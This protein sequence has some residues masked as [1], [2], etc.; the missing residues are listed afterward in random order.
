VKQNNQR[1]ELNKEFP[2]MPLKQKNC[3]S[4]TGDTGNETPT[5]KFRKPNAKQKNSIARAQQNHHLSA[6]TAL[7][8]NKKQKTVKAQQETSKAQTQQKQASQDR[9]ETK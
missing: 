1:R 8:K 7:T 2:P 3:E 4:P 9:R 5:Q 6:T